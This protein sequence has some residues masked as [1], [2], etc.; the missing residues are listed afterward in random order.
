MSSD[1]TIFVYFQLNDIIFYN[2]TLKRNHTSN[3]MAWYG[4]RAPGSSQSMFNDSTYDGNLTEIRAPI[5]MEKGEAPFF[6]PFTES[7][8]HAYRRRASNYF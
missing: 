5:T 7:L 1:D 8:N 3:S 2:R 6:S 4:S